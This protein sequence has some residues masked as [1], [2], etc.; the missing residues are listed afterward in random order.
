MKIKFL[1]KFFLLSFFSIF[2]LLEDIV[3]EKEINLLDLYKSLHSHP[4][5]SFQEKQTSQKLALILKNL[6]YKVTQ[7]FGGYGVVAILENGKGKTVMLRADMD[8]LPIEERTGVSYAS[9]KKSFNSE[10]QEVYTM[11]ACGHDIHMTA[12]I[13]TAQNLIKNENKWKGTLIL[14]LQPAEEVSGGARAMLKNGLYSKF[15]RPDYNIALHVSADL[16]AGK[17]GYIPGYAMANVDSVDILIKGIGGHGAYPHKTKDPIVLASQLVM[18]LQTIVSREISP[19]EPAVI[20]VGSF[21]AGTKHNIIPNEVKLQLT[22]RSY[23]DEVRQKTIDSITR[24]AENLAQS[25][26]LPQSLYPEIVIK[27]EYTPAVFNDPN[28]T[29][30]LRASFESSLGEENVIRVLPVMAGEDFGM[31]GRTDP[32]VPTAL[33]WL[34]AVNQKDYKLAK[35]KNNTLPSLHSN[36]FLPDPVTTIK[37][38]VQ[39][40]TKA[41]YDL[42]N[43]ED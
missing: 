24:I 31:F 11:H 34:G 16:E 21:H 4:E 43:L 3:A 1:R 41:L 20:T 22:L 13:G 23:T 9:R 27:D 38:G 2:F 33:F 36:Q 14:I 12:L 35:E 40:S 42:F 28:L 6:G 30:K 39:V 29:N 32:P 15:P 10:G 37:T 5:L 18:A 26:G 17:V 19:L 7:E 25:S 8:G